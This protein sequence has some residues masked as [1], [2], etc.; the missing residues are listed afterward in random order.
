MAD[1]STDDDV[2]SF[3]PFEGGCNGCDECITH[4]DENGEIPCQRCHGDGR[5][6]WCDYLLPCPECLGDTP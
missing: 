3:D 2:L 5:D 6:P 1:Q 4:D